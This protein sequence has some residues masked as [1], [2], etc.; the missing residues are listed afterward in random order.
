MPLGQVLVKSKY[1]VTLCIHLDDSLFSMNHDKPGYEE[2][3]Q[4]AIPTEKGRDR[5]RQFQNL[6]RYGLAT[7]AMMDV[8]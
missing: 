6:Y 3:S 7:S 8:Q 1:D 5:F 2:K 4:I